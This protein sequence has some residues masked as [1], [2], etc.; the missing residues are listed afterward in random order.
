MLEEASEAKGLSWV[1]PAVSGDLH[2]WV[3]G[4][5]RVDISATDSQIAA[6]IG[7]VSDEVKATFGDDIKAILA[8]Q[9]MS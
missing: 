8:W 7:A 5:Q 6:L 4:S 9:A 3:D 1:E 2:T